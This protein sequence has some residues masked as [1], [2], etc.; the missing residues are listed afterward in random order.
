MAAILLECA[1]VSCIAKLDNETYF[2]K[3]REL[4]A[5]GTLSGTRRKGTGDVAE[6]VGRDLEVWFAAQALRG[7]LSMSQ[8]I[9][10]YSTSSVLLGEFY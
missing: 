6:S 1:H 9:S 7:R 4:V 8:P 2:R 5:S 10:G 3:E